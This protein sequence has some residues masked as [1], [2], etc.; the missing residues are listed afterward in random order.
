MAMNIKRA[1][2]D[3]PPLQEGIIALVVTIRACLPHTVFVGTS[4]WPAGGWIAVVTQSN[5]ELRR[6][7]GR[8][9]EQAVEMLYRA[10]LDDA[11]KMRAALDRLID[12]LDN[13][14]KRRNEVVVEATSTEPASRKSGKGGAKVVDAE[15]EE[16][17]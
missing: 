14:D 9:P 2:E 3:L 6:A 7:A 17:E 13:E 16:S 8:T 12:Q 5:M 15:F 1:S 10:L 4:P 11:H